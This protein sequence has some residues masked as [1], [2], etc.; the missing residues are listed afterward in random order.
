M[1]ICQQVWAGACEPITTG[2]GVTSTRTANNTKSG[3]ETS[4]DALYCKRDKALKR[5]VAAYTVH[6]ISSFTH[7]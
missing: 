2:S 3:E 6:E 4:L 1:E 7:G 5:V